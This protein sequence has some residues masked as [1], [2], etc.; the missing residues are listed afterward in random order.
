VDKKGRT[1]LT[2][3]SLL[4]S[5]AVLVALAMIPLVW[6]AGIVGMPTMADV[7]AAKTADTVGVWLFTWSL[8][9]VASMAA[10]GVAWAGWSWD[11]DVARSQDLQKTA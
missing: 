2:T 10:I 7:I 4:R 6:I 8:I 5:A 3:H 1:E 9:V 11:R